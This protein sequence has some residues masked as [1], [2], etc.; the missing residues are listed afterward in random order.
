MREP[1]VEG[2]RATWTDTLNR[3]KLQD[4]IRTQMFFIL[5]TIVSIRYINA[6]RK[7]NYAR[8]QIKKNKKINLSALVHR[9]NVVVNSE[10]SFRLMGDKLLTQL[11]AN[12]SPDLNFLAHKFT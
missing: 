4:R 3:N 11:R 1:F 7:E 12:L 5:I 8:W 6:Y 2:C 10:N 9:G